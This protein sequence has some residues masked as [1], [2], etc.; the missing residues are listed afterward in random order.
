MANTAAF[1][2][3]L[4]AAQEGNIKIMGELRENNYI[5][6]YDVVKHIWFMDADTKPPA[7]IIGL[8]NKWWGRRRQRQGEKT[9]II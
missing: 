9:K 3:F 2:S 5:D 4:K 1:N 7:E 6:I 8:I